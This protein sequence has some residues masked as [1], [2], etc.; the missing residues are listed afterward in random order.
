MYDFDLASKILAAF[1]PPKRLTPA[2]WA[3]QNIVLP[4]ESNAEP[5]PLRLTRYQRGMVDAVA[6]ECA[7]TLVF[8]LASQTGKSISIDCALGF[9]MAQ[10]PGPVLHVSPTEGKAVDFV[11]N[12]L[13]PV[14]KASPGLRKIVGGGRKGGGDSLTHKLFP[15]GSLNVASSFKPD[16]LAARAIR[17]LFLDEIDRFAAS[18]GSEGD[19]VT[20]A[21]KRTRTFRNRKRII[22]STPT[23]KGASRVKE[24]FDRGTQER[25]FCPCPECGAFDYFRF[26][27]LKWEK[28]KPHTARLVCDDCGHHLTEAERL[29]AIDLGDWQPTNENPEP[30]IRSFH[31]TELVS[32]FSSLASV[33]QQREEADTPEKLRVFHNTTLAEVFDDGGELKVD[34]TELQQ[35]AEPVRAPYPAEIDMVVAGADVQAERLEVSFVGVNVTDK[36]AWVLNHIVLH[37]DT[38][39]AQVWR[40]FDALLGGAVFVL[41][42]GRRL[43]LSACAIDSGYNTSNVAEFCAAQRKKSRNVLA[44]KGVGGFDKPTIRKGSK[45]RNMTTLYLVGVDGVKASIHRRLNMQEVG[46]NFIHLPDHLD[47]SYFEGLTVETLKTRFVRGYARQEFHMSSRSGGGNEPL[48]ALAYALAV[49]TMTKPPPKSATPKPSIADAAARLAALHDSN[50]ENIT[51]ERYQ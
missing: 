35:R 31:A 23:A 38:S 51:H 11:R 18:A 20:L 7:D 2:E 3:E 15:G 28:G 37:G 29:R 33:A 8:M 44:V 41:R 6:D 48:D 46:P 12:R 34:A 47:A 13:D 21:T 40:D 26:E 27:Q 45:L 16:D 39:G 1:K 50:Q 17:W 4:S 9:A 43:M 30:G 22:A 42:D 24:W 49:A 14:I 19:P 32:V 10:D 25:F 5:G 36:R